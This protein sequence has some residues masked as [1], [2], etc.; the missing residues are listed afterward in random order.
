MNRIDEIRSNSQ[1]DYDAVRRQREEKI[2][3]LEKQVSEPW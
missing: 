3:Q 2:E 1:V